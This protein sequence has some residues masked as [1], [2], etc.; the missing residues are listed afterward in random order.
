[1]KPDTSSDPVSFAPLPRRSI[2][3]CRG[4]APPQGRGMTCR[5]CTSRRPA[6]GCWRS[7]PHSPC[8]SHRRSRP[9]R[10]ATSRRRCWSRL[11]AS[12][13]AFERSTVRRRRDVF[14]GAGFQRCDRLL[15][16]VD[17]ELDRARSR[18][19]VP[20][21]LHGLRAS[22]RLA[23]AGV[24][25]KFPKLVGRS[26]VRSDCPLAR[27]RAAAGL[28]DVVGAVK[29]RARRGLERLMPRSSS[30][31]FEP[32]FTCASS[33]SVVAVKTIAL[34]PAASVPPS[35]STLGDEDPPQPAVRTSV[36]TKIN[37]PAVATAR[38]IPRFGVK[39]KANL[40]WRCCRRPYLFLTPAFCTR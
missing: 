23:V 21:H 40:S 12:R 20:D 28:V 25:E 33:S 26:C 17:Q 9:L 36:S 5:S 3:E 22:G 37:V 14:V 1:M 29:R 6:A 2:P 15:L 8:R 31:R 11:T 16:A 24:D 35:S 7:P 30:A 19:R 39:V 32:T 38:R 27:F 34:P 4:S 10:H 18:R 13:I